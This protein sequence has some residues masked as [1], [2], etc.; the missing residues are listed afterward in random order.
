[1]HIP[2]ASEH[3]ASLALT[4]PDFDLVCRLD[5]L[6]LSLHLFSASGAA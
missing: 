2:R 5:R 1:M 4:L 3:L 6:Q